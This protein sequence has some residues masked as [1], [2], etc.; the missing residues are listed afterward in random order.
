MNEGW[1]ERVLDG[2]VRIKKIDLESHRTKEMTPLI[3]LEAGT[4]RKQSGDSGGEYAV[5]SL[6]KMVQRES[7]ITLEVSERVGLFNCQQ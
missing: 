5:P 7:K 3:W 2:S 1:W 4:R 6:V